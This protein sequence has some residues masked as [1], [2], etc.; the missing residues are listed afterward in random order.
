MRQRLLWKL[1]IGH[2]VPVFAIISLL[3]WRA[4]D[5]QASDYYTVLVGHFHVAPIFEHRQFLGVIHRDLFWGTLTALALT[6]FLTY[7]LTHWVLRPLF[8]DNRHHQEGRRR[9][10]F[11]A[12]EGRLPL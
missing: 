3:V 2:I 9:Q 8:P 12:G 4:I 5:R 6:L 11:R 7:L 10:L 1:L